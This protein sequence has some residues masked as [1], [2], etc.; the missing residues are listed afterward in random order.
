MIVV[1]QFFIYSSKIKSKDELHQR[2]FNMKYKIFAI[3]KPKEYIT[4]TLRDYGYMPHRNTS[5][6]DIEKAYQL[7][8]E[9]N[10]VN[11]L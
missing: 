7:S 2:Q 5:N 1:S 9:L 10:S 6:K 4:I 8:L 11:V 3:I